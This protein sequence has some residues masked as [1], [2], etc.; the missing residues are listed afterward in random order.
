MRVLFLSLAGSMVLWM[1]FGVCTFSETLEYQPT[2]FEKDSIP[3]SKSDRISISR[4]PRAPLFKYCNKKKQVW[5]KENQN[6]SNEHLIQYISEN[7]RYSKAT[8]RDCQGLA[9]I[10]LLLETNGK[11]KDWEIIKLPCDC[12]KGDIDAFIQK[13]PSFEFVPDGSQFQDIQ[14][15]HLSIR[16]SLD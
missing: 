11:I 15:F 8:C 10:K 14:F 13:I 6:C 2:V 5:E 16:F 4:K 12:L 1:I 7:F 9:V 3:D